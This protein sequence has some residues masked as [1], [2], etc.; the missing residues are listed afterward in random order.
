MESLHDLIYSQD[1]NQFNESFSSSEEETATPKKS[2]REKSKKQKQQHQ[3]QQQPS[4]SARRL[5]KVNDRTVEETASLKAAQREATNLKRRLLN[6]KIYFGNEVH[7]LLSHVNELDRDDAKHLIMD[8]YPPSFSSS[9]TIY[10]SFNFQNV[11]PTPQLWPL[12]YS[13]PIEHLSKYKLSQKTPIKLIQKSFAR[14]LL[15]GA[16]AQNDPLNNQHLYDTA[17]AENLP[18]DTDDQETKS[19]HDTLLNRTR[20]HW[21]PWQQTLALFRFLHVDKINV[22]GNSEKQDYI[23]HLK[24]P[25]WIPLTSEGLLRLW[26]HPQES[27]FEYYQSSLTKIFAH[28]MTLD[29][30]E[31]MMH[32]R[33]PAYEH[34]VAHHELTKT[35]TPMRK[36]LNT[37]NPI[38]FDVVHIHAITDRTSVNTSRDYL[39]KRFDFE[40]QLVNHNIQRL[41]MAMFATYLADKEGSSEESDNESDMLDLQVG[42]LKQNPFQSEHHEYFRS[43]LDL[44]HKRVKIYCLMNKSKIQYYP[45]VVSLECAQALVCHSS[46]YVQESAVQQLLSLE[47]DSSVAYKD[48]MPKPI[49][50]FSMSFFPMVLA[51]LLHCLPESCKLTRQ[52]FAKA[53]TISRKVGGIFPLDMPSNPFDFMASAMHTLITQDVVQMFRNLNDENLNTFDPMAD[54]ETLILQEVLEIGKQFSDIAHD[55]LETTTFHD[56]TAHLWYTAIM[57]SS[58]IL[59]SEHIFR[60]YNVPEI[61]IIHFQESPSLFLHHR[62]DCA[63][64]IRHLFHLLSPIT[65]QKSPR[66]HFSDESYNMS[67]TPRSKWLHIQGSF[68]YRVF[69][70]LLEWKT[71]VYL[72]CRTGKKEDLSSMSKLHNLCL[73]EWLT[74]ESTYGHNLHVLECARYLWT[75]VQILNRDSFLMILANTLETNPSR[76]D[77]WLELIYHL[78]PWQPSKGDQNWTRGKSWWAHSFFR[79]ETNHPIGKPIFVPNFTCKS[80]AKIR[81]IPS[82]KI[83]RI[84]I[85][86]Q[87]SPELDPSI[88]FDPSHEKVSESQIKLEL[89]PQKCEDQDDSFSAA[90]DD[91][92]FLISDQPYLNWISD[93]NNMDILE[94]MDDQDA[95]SLK[96]ENSENDEN[97]SGGGYF[98]LLDLHG[99]ERHKEE[100]DEEVIIDIPQ[101]SQE[102]KKSA[103]YRHLNE[104]LKLHTLENMT[105][106]LVSP[107]KEELEIVLF[108]L[109]EAF[110]EHLMD[111]KSKHKSRYIRIF[112]NVVVAT[113][114]Y[115]WNHSFVL[116]SIIGLCEESCLRSN[117]DQSNVAVQSPCHS[118]PLCALAWL[119][120]F[121]KIPLDLILD[122]LDRSESSEMQLSFVNRRSRLKRFKPFS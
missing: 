47:Q 104:H 4:S 6:R 38:Y 70:S 64:A 41:V 35:N 28:N 85:L 36:R 122:H 109:L 67:D 90:L 106:E 116:D 27:V 101:V 17:F 30:V 96:T 2:T 26:E 79:K 95:F 62:R 58:L 52:M 55:W 74:K 61:Q 1:Q 9:I 39:E 73:Q 81:W 78:G 82:H 80:T 68:K 51:K 11:Y 84:R 76:M 14:F 87:K 10:Q 98:D 50:Y 18:I 5:P 48:L 13:P 83:S 103:V 121:Y 93:P 99:D 25:L 111:D 108:R 60:F 29:D 100:D 110:Q 33:S 86:L 40:N 112:I 59:K 31:K 114:L 113:H 66:N 102:Q 119:K 115:G 105:H 69:M 118:P 54:S 23:H 91:N 63:K 22:L 19:H 46:T 65:T 45:Y 77:L 42:D 43:I 75:Q 49:K 97:D 15:Q 88:F 71:A 7:S 20:L 44:H 89:Q 34:V 16:T 3:Q 57:L 32:D 53:G 107:A 24:L 92:P 117:Y 37:L 21:T 12:I 8:L 72:V 56:L 120:E 94:M